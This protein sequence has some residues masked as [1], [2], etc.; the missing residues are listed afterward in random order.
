[1]DYGMDD[2]LSQIDI[3]DGVSAGRCVVRIGGGDAV[4]SPMG[5]QVKRPASGSN[6]APVGSIPEE[7]RSGNPEAAVTSKESCEPERAASRQ[8]TFSG[9]A[10]PAWMVMSSCAVFNAESCPD[11]N[12]LRGRRLVDNGLEGKGGWKERVDWRGRVA[13]D[14]GSLTEP[15]LAYRSRE[16]ASATAEE[17]SRSSLVTAPPAGTSLVE[18]DKERGRMP[19]TGMRSDKA[20]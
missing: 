4:A 15:S 12:Q 7:S 20:L 1:M 13:M 2:R 6:A 3:D 11:G 8:G 17:F 5:V 19:L 18:Q 10:S 9:G 14:E 16:K